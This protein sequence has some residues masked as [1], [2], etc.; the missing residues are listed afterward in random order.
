MDGNP[1]YERFITVPNLGLYENWQNDGQ[2]EASLDMWDRT[3]YYMN[4]LSLYEII[5]ID[6]ATKLPIYVA[7]NKSSYSYKGQDMWEIGIKSEDGKSAV[8]GN[9]LLRDFTLEEKVEAVNKY[10]K[11]NM[12]KGA[13]SQVIVYEGAD[14]IVSHSQASCYYDTSVDDGKK[15]K[16]TMLPLL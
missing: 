1:L 9:N 2:Y 6:S 16:N 12:P 3:A 8:R 11:Q 5:G 4:G 10:L 7:V 14:F 13:N 15:H